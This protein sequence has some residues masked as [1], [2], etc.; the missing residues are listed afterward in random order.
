MICGLFKK[1]PQLLKMEGTENKMKKLIFVLSLALTIFLPINK[2]SAL[3]T[4]NEF[5]TYEYDTYGNYYE[6]VVTYD[7]SFARASH[8]VNGH[9]TTAYKTS[10][11]K[12][13]W[14]VTVNGSFNYN[15]STS[16]CISASASTSAPDATWKISNKSSSRSGNTAK[17]NATAICYLNGHP[18]NSATKTVILKCSASGKLS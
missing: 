4:N 12:T 8:S 5:T 13:L 9:K 10:A 14:S 7:T 11:G 17:A 18:I 2:V 3:E 16:N 15:G 6:T 1:K